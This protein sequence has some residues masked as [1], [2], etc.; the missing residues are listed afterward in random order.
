MRGRMPP[1]LMTRSINS[2]PSSMMVKSA[3][4]VDV[5]HLVEAQ[6]AQGG[7]HL[8]LD[9]GAD[10]QAEALA[11]GDPDGGGGAAPP[12]AWRGRSGR[13]STL[14]GVVLFG[15][16]R[17]WGRPRC[18]G[19]R[20]RRPP[21]PDPGRR[22]QPMWVSKPRSLGPMTAHLL[23]L[24]AH[25]GAAAAEDALGV[26]PHQVGGGV[27]QSGGACCRWRTAPRRCRRSPASWSSSQWLLREQVRQSIRWLERISSRVSWRDLRTRSVL[28]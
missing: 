12:R 26:V 16:G 4:V 28:V 17:R 2:V 22:Q 19:R 23:G 13:P 14:G 9:V 18:T 20:R 25:G 24:A 10:G 1:P 5:E 15:R 27:P 7:D 6:A 3:A 21:R 11:Q 8:A